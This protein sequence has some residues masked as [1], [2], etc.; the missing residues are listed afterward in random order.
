[1]SKSNP[2]V[3]QAGPG[4][5]RLLTL[6][7]PK[8]LAPLHRPVMIAIA[9]L[10]MLTAIMHFSSYVDYVGADNDDVLRLVQ[11]RDLLSGKGWFDLTQMRLGLEG[12]TPMHWSRLIDLPIASLILCSHWSWIRSMAEATALFVWPLITVLPVFYAWHWPARPSPAPRG[13]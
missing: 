3:S 8:T 6:R 2:A 9:V 10:T 12:G 7:G 13:G 11:V 4:S 1:V 5:K